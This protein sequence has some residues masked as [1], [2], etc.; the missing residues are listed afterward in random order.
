M[1][2]YG[3]GF[4]IA[5][6]VV[7]AAAMGGVRFAAHEI[8]GTFGAIGGLLVI[9]AMYGAAVLYDRRAKRRKVEVIPP[10]ATYRAHR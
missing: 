6:I 2:K 8:V 10:E 4:L 5:C 3:A 9:A 1:V 7:Y